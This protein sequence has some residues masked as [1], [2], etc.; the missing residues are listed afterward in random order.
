MGACLIMDIRT[1]NEDPIQIH[2]DLPFVESE[3]VQPGETHVPAYTIEGPDNYVLGVE[4]NTPLAPE[5][6]TASGE[7][8]DNSTRVL[9][10][11]ADPQGNPLGNAII[12]EHNLD[13]FDFEKM[14]SD[15]RFFRHTQKSLLLDEKEYL[16]VYVD[17]P[18]GADPLDPQ[19]SRLTIGDNVTQTGKAVYIRKK[20]SLN[21]MESSAVQAASSGGR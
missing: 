8:L 9:L 6:R 2:D 14:R 13:A 12:F 10:Q 7:K 19:M 16:Y 4:A 11:K 20:D 1:T 17:I 5:L 18:S 3:Q 21:G 15:P